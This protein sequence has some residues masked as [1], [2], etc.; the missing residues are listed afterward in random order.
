MASITIPEGEE[1]SVLIINFK[2]LMEGL[3]D[4]ELDEVVKDVLEQEKVKRLKKS[5]KKTSKGAAKG[6]VVSFPGSFNNDIYKSL[7]NS[8]NYFIENQKEGGPAIFHATNLRDNLELYI[9]R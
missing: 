5:A 8:V 3:R 9:G 4:Y 2:M 6:K 1:P 7:L